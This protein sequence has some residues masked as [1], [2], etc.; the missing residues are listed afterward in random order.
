MRNAPSPVNCPYCGQPAC[1]WRTRGAVRTPCIPR[2]CPYCGKP[3]IIDLVG[4]YYCPYHKFT[5]WQ[6]IKR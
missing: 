4:D 1:V 5:I 3:A 6:D 2:H